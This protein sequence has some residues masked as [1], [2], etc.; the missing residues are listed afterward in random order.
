MAFP[1]SRQLRLS[2]PANAPPLPSHV[3]ERNLVRTGHARSH[4][5][6]WARTLRRCQQTL[7]RGAASLSDALS[8]QRTPDHPRSATPRASRTTSAAWCIAL[9]QISIFSA[10]S[11]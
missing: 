7:L 4:P 11:I 8:Q 2:D 1:L 9:A 3:L 10:I 5:H 6:V